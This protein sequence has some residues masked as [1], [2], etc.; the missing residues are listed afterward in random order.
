MCRIAADM[1]NALWGP[2][3]FRELDMIGETIRRLREEKCWSQAHLADASRLNI[4]TIQRIESGET[5][6]DE[7]MLSL[8]AALGVDVSQLNSQPRPSPGSAILARTAV[9]AVLAAPAAIFVL[10]NLL[11]SSAGVSTPY[12]ALAAIG[13]RMMSFHAFNV[14]S[15]V[16]FLG[17]SAAAA[18][19]C[20][21]SLVTVRR[22]VDRGVVRVSGLEVALRPVPWITLLVAAASGAALLAYAAAEQLRTPL[23]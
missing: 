9:A 4:R 20:L 2:A 1:G 21:S 14:A 13:A 7:T 6:S 8:A 12:R 3:C 5:C 18:M 16:I 19:L 22:K 10:V 23:S 17:G 11:G 15:P